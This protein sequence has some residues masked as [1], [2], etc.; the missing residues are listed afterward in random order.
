M[1]LQN[2]YT[3][4]YYSIVSL[5]KARDTNINQYLEKHHII[6]RSMEGSNNKDNIVALT[7]REHFV[8]HVLLT[9]MTSGVAHYKMVHAAIGMKR[10]RKYQERYINSRLYETIKKERG[11][12]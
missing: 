12:S 9:K 6:P 3:K 4:W 8:C 5:A 2:K 7:G 1:Y 11:L 10:A